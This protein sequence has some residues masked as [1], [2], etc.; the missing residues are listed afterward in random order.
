MTL[1]TFYPDDAPLVTDSAFVA[2]IT[3]LEKIGTISINQQR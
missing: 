2:W 3:E 1:E